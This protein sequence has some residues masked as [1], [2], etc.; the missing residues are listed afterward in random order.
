M[1]QGLGYFR[2]LLLCLWVNGFSLL[3][4]HRHWMHAWYSLPVCCPCHIAINYRYRYIHHFQ[5]HSSFRRHLKMHYFQS[6]YPA[7]SGPHN[8]PWFSSETLALYKSLTYL[9]TYL[10]VPHWLNVADRIRFRLCI[11]VFKCQ[12]SMAPGYLDEDCR[13]VCGIDGHR[14]LRSARCG[15]LDAFHKLDCLST[16]GWCAFSHAGPSTWNAVPVCLKNN[17]LSLSNFRHRLKHFY[18]LSY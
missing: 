3:Q 8:A 6:A 15:Q 17:T 1:Q 18:F 10:K 12:H 14:H 9:L 16:Y 7:P 2:Y 13:P 5:I 4:D 11:Q